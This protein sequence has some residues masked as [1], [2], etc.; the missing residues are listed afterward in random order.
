MPSYRYQFCDLL[1]DQH[2]TDLALS[3]VRYGRRIVQPGPF[4]ARVP[5]TN[6]TTAQ[7]V[8]R[9]LPPREDDISTGPGRTICHVWRNGQ[10]WGSYIIWRGRVSS[11][12]RGRITAELSGESLESWFHRVQIDSTQTYVQQDQLFIAREIVRRKQAQT[13]GGA[14]QLGIIGGGPATSG[15][16]RD[17][18]YS[19]HDL[20]TVGERLEQ[21]SEVIG[22]PEWYVRTYPNA[23]GAR[24]REF[25]VAPL[26][27]NTARTH[28]FAQPGN[29]L[30]WSHSVDAT[31]TGTHYTARGDAADGNGYRSVFQVFS[32]DHRSAGW[33]QLEETRDYPTVTSGS[34]LGDYAAW[35]AA[36]RAGAQHSLQ[37]DVRL[38]ESPTL[39]PDRLGERARLTLVNDW[40]PLDANGAPTFDEIRR[41]IGMEIAAP[42]RGQP[43]RVTLLLEGPREGGDTS[44]RGAPMY[45]RDLADQLDARTRQITRPVLSSTAP[46]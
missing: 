46:I 21:L 18:T 12:D 15:V 3:G 29:V 16:L 43:E 28:V 10:L 30:S 4:S 26:L 9:I 35:W 19:G 34:T 45:A 20:A 23:S 17:R 22:G 42:D 36:H 7:Q 13:S 33:A 24:V 44:P 1:T 37:V 39:T 14:L 40:W 6:R 8:A 11:D 38:G 32:Q 31:G 41:V 2:I 5:I 25:Y 27:G